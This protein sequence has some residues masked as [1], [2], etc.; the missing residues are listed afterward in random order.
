MNYL[1]F[2]K[3]N[4]FIMNIITY[5]TNFHRYY[6]ILYNIHNSSFIILGYVYLFKMCN[7][8]L[9][10]KQYFLCLAK[11]IPYIKDEINKKKQ[12][13]KENIKEELNRPILDLQLN[14]KIPDERIESEEIL[15][16]INKTKL[17]QPFKINEGKISGCVYDNDESSLELMKNILPLYERSNPLHPDIYPDVRKMEAEIINMCGNLLKLKNP[18]IG[19]FTSGGTESILL[20]MRSYKKISDSLGKR[21]NI[22]LAKSAHAAYWK[23]SEYFNINIIEIETYDKPLNSQYLDKII[24]SNLEKI[25]IVI[26]SAPSFNFGIVDDI[27]DLSYFCCNNG[28]Y[29]HV[30]MCLGGF[31]IPFYK[32]IKCDFTL[33][34]INSISLDTHKYGYGP[35]GGSVLLYKN[36]DLFKYHCFVKD[37]WTG[38]I[39]GTSNLTG[40][41]SGLIISLTWAVMLNTGLINYQK[42]ALKIRELTKYLSSNIKKN[43]NL[44]I[45]GEPEVCIVA[46]G[47]DKFNIYLLSDKLKDLGWSLNILQNP[48]SFHFCI[49][50]IHNEEMINN[51][52]FD[53]NSQ[54][55]VIMNNPNLNS[56]QPVCIYG[57]TQKVNDSEIVTDVVKEYICSLT[58]LT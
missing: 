18:E 32:T 47:S 15:E 57:T 2:L 23:A 1:S 54:T 39:Y 46:I 31:L 13:I 4:S 50:S 16:I 10:N 14:L 37:D 6:N 53:I 38:G 58:E 40:S 24:E 26:A 49:T 33:P 36:R 8:N 44:K 25:N 21:C 56:L 51:L 52:I 41:R 29:L 22:I 20:A 30:D 55:N 28:I 35:K 48:P 17:I 19:C 43:K 42:K 45:F 11:K 12:Q 9:F 7:E 5:F 34:G 3:D 27:E